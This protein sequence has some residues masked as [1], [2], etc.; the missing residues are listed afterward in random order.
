MILEREVT[1]PV[2]KPLCGVGSRHRRA[3]MRVDQTLGA[4]VVLLEKGL[5]EKRTAGLGSFLRLRCREGGNWWRDEDDDEGAYRPPCGEGRPSRRSDR[6]QDGLCRSDQTLIE[7]RCE[8]L[9][10]V[11]PRGHSAAPPLG[12]GVLEARNCP[13]QY[14]CDV[15]LAADAE[16]RL[17]AFQGPT[18]GVLRD[19]LPFRVLEER[20]TERN[21]RGEARLGGCQIE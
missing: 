19:A 4:A 7:G 17:D 2:A 14:A 3:H 6:A 18:C 5:I 15:E 10:A 20:F 8:S 16:L 11:R 21:R 12:T 13:Q 1:I 9:H